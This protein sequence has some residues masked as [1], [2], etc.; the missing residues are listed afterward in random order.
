MMQT[1]FIMGMPIILNISGAPRE[2]FGKI[3]NYFRE[4]DNKF[5]PFK[6]DSELSKINRGE[7]KIPDQEMELIFKLAQKTKVETNGFFD[8]QK[9]DKIDTCG[10]VKGWAISEAAKKLFAMGF[11][12]FFINAGG[13]IQA[14]G[15]KWKV[16]IQNPFKVNQV[17][18]V[19]YLENTGIAT[20]G[21]Y[22]RGKHIYNP[23]M[24]WEPA[25][26]IASVTVIAADVYDADRFATAAFA[27]GKKGIEFI[28]DHPALEGY[29][30]D[31]KGVA[32][33]TSGFKKYENN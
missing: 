17:V 30:I 6:K 9:K 1:R 19:L 20:S 3:F 27:M 11:G 26:E 25:D 24:N 8:I 4:V 18:K 21:N 5:S 7:I 31:K 15:K 29:M 28:E 32:T 16:G 23:K 14:V 22:V 33:Y 12:E 10:I 2:I 13:D